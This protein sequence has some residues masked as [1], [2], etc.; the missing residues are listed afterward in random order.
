MVRKQIFLFLYICIFNL[1]DTQRENLFNSS[2]SKTPEKTH[3]QELGSVSITVESVL[4]CN[5]NL[6]NFRYF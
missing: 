4:V 5:K 3:D 1:K 6:S 2:Q